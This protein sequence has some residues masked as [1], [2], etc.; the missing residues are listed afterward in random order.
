MGSLQ[1]HIPSLD[2]LRG[3]AALAVMISHYSEAEKVA[4]NFFTANGTL[5]VLVFFALSGFIMGHIYDEIFAG[6]TSVRTYIW[7]LS[8][9]IAKLYP[10][11]IAL[12]FIFATLFLR[13]HVWAADPINNNYSLALNVFM[14]HGWGFLPTYTWNLP[15]WSISMEWFCYLLFP[16]ICRISA[17]RQPFICL[18]LIIFLL[19]SLR[20]DWLI[21]ALAFVTDSPANFALGGGRRMAFYFQIFLVGY[22]AYLARR[23]VNM[24]VSGVA[25]DMLFFITCAGVW[26]MGPQ[27]KA[28]PTIAVAVVVLLSFQSTT[29]RI[30]ANPVFVYLGRIS[31]SLYM[32]HVMFYALIYSIWARNGGEGRLSVS[33]LV[34]TGTIAASIVFHL[35]EEPARRRVRLLASRKVN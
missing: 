32:T 18:T 27:V 20:F 16:F 1:K 13:F 22:L 25:I 3:L 15:S 5:G 17:L 8:L 14:I 21:S 28:M 12:T 29:A 34:V 7:F 4:L 33:T 26:M 23:S 10:L 2:G 6:V 35:F 11:H 30:F 24:K 31:Y 9:R 19:L